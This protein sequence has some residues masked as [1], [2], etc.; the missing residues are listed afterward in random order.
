M[1]PFRCMKEFPEEKYIDLDNNPYL[2]GRITVHLV[3]SEFH[4]EIDIIHKESHKIF[5]HVDIIYNQYTA[6]DAFITGVQ[7][8]RQFI[9]KI[10]KAAEDKSKDHL[11]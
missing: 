8:L 11:H 1:I 2:L 6:E 9:I 3:K 5:K 10:E 7:R 4:A